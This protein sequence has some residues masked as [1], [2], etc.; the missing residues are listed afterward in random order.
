LLKNLNVEKGLVNGARGIVMKIND[1]HNAILVKF[2][3]LSNINTINWKLLGINL[4]HEQQQLSLS[5]DVNHESLFPISFKSREIDIKA[6]NEDLKIRK[7]IIYERIQYPIMVSFAISIHKSQSV[8][9]SSVIIDAGTSIF[10][11]GQSYVALSRC[12]SL[13]GIYLLNIDIKKINA[14]HRAKKYDTDIRKKAY[15]IKSF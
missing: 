2:E 4:T 3:T 1:V 14:D 7:Y 6:N 10:T 12:K 11:P 15:F 8:T 5:S 13:D 9:L